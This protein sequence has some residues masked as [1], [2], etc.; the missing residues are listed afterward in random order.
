MWHYTELIA[1]QTKDKILITNV[2]LSVLSY[3]Q[4][5]PYENEIPLLS[6]QFSKAF[7]RF[8]FLCCMRSEILCYHFG[9]EEDTILFFFFL[10]RIYMRRNIHENGWQRDCDK[11][12]YSSV[13]EAQAINNLH[14]SMT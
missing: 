3:K 2:A 8:V 12:C 1:S 13:Y 14:R 5:S 6:H 10:Y 4:H 11:L 9:V 7:N